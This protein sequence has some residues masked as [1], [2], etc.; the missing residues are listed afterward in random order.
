MVKLLARK[1]LKPRVK[2]KIGINYKFVIALK[3]ARK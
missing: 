3:T 1:K 2:N